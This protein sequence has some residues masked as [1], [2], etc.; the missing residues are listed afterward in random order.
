MSG[1]RNKKQNKKASKRPTLG[2]KVSLDNET[3]KVRDNVRLE[4]FIP[5]DE[6]VPEG[7]RVDR[8]TWCG[9][10]SSDTPWYEVA[11]EGIVAITMRAKVIV[12][13][14]LTQ[15][16]IARGE[17]DR[18]SNVVRDALKSTDSSGV[19]IIRS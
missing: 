14:K 12:P 8:F 4:K 1:N 19:K 13:T 6:D 10:N 3:E 11:G 2:S 7:W 15:R 17:D 16:K 9:R 5:F 18:L